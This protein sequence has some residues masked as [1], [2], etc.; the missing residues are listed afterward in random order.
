MTGLQLFLRATFDRT[1]ATMN[2]LSDV[3]RVVQ[4]TGAVYLDAALSE[5]WC[6]I[7]QAESKLC[8]IYL[9]P[10]ERVIAFHLI[11]EGSCWAMLPNERDSVI[12]LD[13][14]DLMVVPQGDSHV[15]GSSLDRDPEL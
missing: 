13:A 15:V 14:G 3:L 8:A 12:R 4:L 10:T 1:A 6:V 5:P 7:G 11:T 9:P 2:A